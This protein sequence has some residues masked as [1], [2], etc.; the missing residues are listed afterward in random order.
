MD[1]EDNPPVAADGSLVRIVP[2]S[3]LAENSDRYTFPGREVC[4]AA[5]APEYEAIVFSWAI[6]GKAVESDGRLLKFTPDIPGTY[7]ISVEAAVKGAKHIGEC[8]VV[9]VDATE[10]SRRRVAT[11]SSSDM[12]TRV[13]EYLP[14]PGQFVGDVKNAGT[15]A[16]A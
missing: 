6:N 7:H 2:L 4:L 10:E 15:P 8:D 9:A 5:V 14:A 11:A 16:E 1:G 3:S 13:F 12:A